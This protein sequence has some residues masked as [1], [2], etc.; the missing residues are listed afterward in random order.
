M[1]KQN[2][3][4][5]VKRIN[6][7]Q[8]NYKFNGQEAQKAKNSRNKQ[9]SKNAILDDQANDASDL[10]LVKSE[11][12]AAA[13]SDLQLTKLLKNNVR[14]NE[15]TTIS[16]TSSS[17]NASMTN[18]QLSSLSS[19]IA[20][21]K[22]NEI[23]RFQCWCRAF[24]QHRTIESRKASIELSCMYLFS[25]FLF[26]NYFSIESILWSLTTGHRFCC[27]NEKFLLNFFLCSLEC[28]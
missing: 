27:C 24:G 6:D 4:D 26:K 17:L 9:Y 1:S 19:L 28:S 20:L 7:I 15:T 8:T 25:S 12:T 2:L 5:H 18:S 11:Q 10:P 23:Y 21:M 3:E 13:Q 14:L 22:S 16:P